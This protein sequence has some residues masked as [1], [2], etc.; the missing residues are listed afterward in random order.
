M[1]LAHMVHIDRIAVICDFA[2]TYH[3][4]DMWALPARTAATLACGLGPNSR[5]MQ[6]LAGV[7]ISPPFSLL[8]A[9]L[10]DEVRAFRY[11]W[12]DESAGEPPSVVDYMT[13]N[14]QEEKNKSAVATYE[15]GAAF[16]EAR[17]AIIERIKR[18]NGG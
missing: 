17:A 8:V 16:D 4:Y 5:I 15:S 1:V 11:M 18:N 14:V 12:A 3:I 10:I 13:G 6:K 7:E 9:L 2:E